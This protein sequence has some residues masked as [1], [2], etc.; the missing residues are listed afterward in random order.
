MRLS[1]DV[2]EPTDLVEVL[3]HGEGEAAAWL[4]AAGFE[5]DAGE[6][7]VGVDRTL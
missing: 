2:D 7:R 6:G 1:T 3:L 4:R 5:L